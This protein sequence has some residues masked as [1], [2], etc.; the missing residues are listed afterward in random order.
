M[1]HE[2]KREEIM[3]T[4]THG[5]QEIQASIGLLKPEIAQRWATHLLGWSH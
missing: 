5:N 4:R 3:K 2:G 1:A